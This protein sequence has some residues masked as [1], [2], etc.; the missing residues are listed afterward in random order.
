[1][2]SFFLL[3]ILIFSFGIWFLRSR[4]GFNDFDVFDLIVGGLI[5]ALLISRILYI[6]E[7][8]EMFNRLG[9]EARPYY[10]VPGGTRVWFQQM[11]WVFLN[12]TD[13][14]ISFLGFYSGFSLWSYLIV[15]FKK[16]I[17]REQA[18]YLIAT[19]LNTFLLIVYI[20]IL[21]NL[22]I[23]RSINSS[24]SN[25]FFIN[26]IGNKYLFTTSLV[27][28]AFSI[29]LLTFLRKKSKYLIGA[30][31]IILGLD[32]L[33]KLI[34]LPDPKESLSSGLIQIIYGVV[35][36]LVGS[37]RTF[38]IARQ[39]KK[40]EDV[41]LKNVS[42]NLKKDNKPI[43]RISSGGS[44]TF[45]RAKKFRSEYK[46]S[47]KSEHKANIFSKFKVRFYSLVRRL[48]K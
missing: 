35:L 43:Q 44:F 10:Y 33:I 28:I 20:G 45:R 14:G 12:L 25:D 41:S 24:F 15:Q 37:I 8:F 40:N 11:P 3:G 47:Y 27:F 23:G 6:I 1:M 32:I 42:F 26:S 4:M 46:A 19:L 5:F 48:S 2:I 7:N 39:E 31:L 13:K 21:V 29:V 30:F 34:Y 9:W 22:I 17:N 38:F 18:Q 16:E 36:V